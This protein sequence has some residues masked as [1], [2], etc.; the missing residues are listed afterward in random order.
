MLQSLVFSLTGVVPTIDPNNPFWSRQLFA[1]LR[2]V[3]RNTI[4]I[5]FLFSSPFHL[6]GVEIKIFNCPAWNI[7]ASAIYVYGSDSNTFPVFLNSIPIGSVNITDIQDCRSLST[8]TVTIPIIYAR[9]KQAYFIEMF[10]GGVPS[11]Q[12]AHQY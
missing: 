10:F 6:R 3:W 2:L 8:V 4:H 7:A 11:A 12:W 9:L 1:V 5:G